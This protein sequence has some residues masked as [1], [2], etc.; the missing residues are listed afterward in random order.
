MN[1]L[2]FR[3]IVSADPASRDAALDG[4]V[5]VCA[6][7]AEFA[8]QMRALDLRIGAAL[9]VPVPDRETQVPP[10][11]S[12]APAQRRWALAASVLVAV[13]TASLVW[14]SFPRASLAQD[15]VAHARH[16]PGSWAEGASHV[17][18]AALDDLLRDSSLVADPGMGRV[19][20]AKSCWFRGHFVPHLV[21]QDQAGPVMVLVMTEETVADRVA[22]V[23]GGYTGV[24]LPA[25]R[26][27]I[28][29]LASEA[30]RVDAVTARVMQALR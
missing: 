8:Q 9:R 18:A 22:F 19:S 11:K 13:V 14:L 12:T 1:C 23:E 26:G 5:R 28:A 17:P 4:H 27:S 3:R 16:E 20:Y 25:R 21:V 15:V 10:V 30:G 6:A 2:E 7:C 29:V 24:I